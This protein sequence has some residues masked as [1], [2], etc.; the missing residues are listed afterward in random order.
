MKAGGTIG[1]ER[2]WVILRAI[3][4][5]GQGLTARQLANLVDVTPRQVRRDLELLSI[6]FPLYW[7]YGDDNNQTRR[8]FVLDSFRPPPELKTERHARILY[9]AFKRGRRAI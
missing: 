4:L 5:N 9:D 7:E 1:I 2:Q 6:L 8:W 3:Q